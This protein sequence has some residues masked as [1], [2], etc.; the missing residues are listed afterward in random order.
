MNAILYSY[1]QCPYC[2][3]SIAALKY[4]QIDVE[5]RGVH[6][7]K[8]PSALTDI[9]ANV[10]VPFLIIDSSNH[11]NESWDIV[12]WALQQNDPEFWLGKGNEF[13]L[14]TEML[15]ET[16]DSFFAPALYQYRQ[17]AKPANNRSDC[18]EYLEEIEDM[19]NEH[20]YLLANHMTIADISIVSFIRLFSLHEPSW[21][22]TAPYPKCRQWLKLISATDYFKTALK[23]HPIWQIGDQ[24]IML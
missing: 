6:L 23:P 1:D 24:P 10:S 7:D 12:K 15:I 22:S 17:S 16:N 3:R 21:F 19:L 11:M 20:E 5:L 8:L 14:D 9:K 13:L 18:E 4:A 2:A